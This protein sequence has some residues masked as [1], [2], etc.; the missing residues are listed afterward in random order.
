MQ[1]PTELR[2]QDRSLVQV[3]TEYFQ[4]H[5]LAVEPSVWRYGPDGGPALLA[6][7][8]LADTIPVTQHLHFLSG[9]RTFYPSKKQSAA[10]DIQAINSLDTLDV[11]APARYIFYLDT[12]TNQE[13]IPRV[14]VTVAS[15]EHVDRERAISSALLETLL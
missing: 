7:G 4:Q 3:L 8:A 2:H 6:Y 10:F 9:S 1:S 5:R 12:K 13:S 14:Y 11:S 15:H